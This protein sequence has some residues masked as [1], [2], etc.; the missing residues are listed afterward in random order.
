MIM[1]D[2]DHFKSINDTFGHQAGDDVLRFFGGLLARECRTGDLVARY[3]GEE[4]VVL[5]ADCNNATAAGRAEDLRKTFSEIPQPSL[6][7]DVVTA[8]FGVTEIQPG[9][10]PASMLRRA[11]RALLEAK[12]LGRN[13]V[14]QLGDGLGDFCET[15]EP[16][17]PATAGTDGDSFVERVLVTAVPLQI[18][19]R[20]AARIRAGPQCPN[21]LDQ[22]RPRRAAH[23]RRS[24]AA[25]VAARTVRSASRSSST[26]PNSACRRPP[27]MAGPPAASPALACVGIRLKKARDRRS[28]DA[29]RPCQHD[30]GQPQELS[31]GQRRRRSRPIRIRSQRAASMTSLWLSG[32]ALNASAQ[33][34][35]ARSP[36]LARARSRPGTLPRGC[37][38]CHFA[39][40]R[41]CWRLAKNN[42]PEDPAMPYQLPPLPYAF[43]ALE[44]HIDA[45]TMEIHHD[46]HHAAYVTNLNKAIEG[47]EWDNKPIEELLRNIEKVPEKIRTAVRNHGGGHA[48]HSMFWTT[49][50]PGK[51]GKPSGKLADAI[52]SQLGG[53]DSFKKE[54][55]AAATGR[56]GSGWAWL[57]RRQ[58][59]KSSSSKARPTRTAR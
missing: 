45:R 59:A 9:D 13:R 7:H 36:Q 52:Q 41:V 58:A 51:G 30:S 1:C 54:F 19:V 33:A 8:S 14:V 6:N 37:D 43:N 4:F 22:E 28:A 48:N 2:L 3:G 27:P 23:R 25:D 47:T 11:D 18:D 57:S 20:K 40:N 32:A 39:L 26:S 49:I 17:L 35:P 42:C 21:R 55:D 24:R 10:S 5:C 12:R 31:D 15:D 29:L 34:P 38:N 16:I 56:F 50:G 44:P 53:F 46:K